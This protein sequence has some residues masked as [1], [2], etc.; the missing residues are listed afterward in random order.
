MLVIEQWQ[1]KSFPNLNLTLAWSRSTHSGRLSPP[2]VTSTRSFSNPISKYLERI[3]VPAGH[4]LWRQG[5][6]SA[7]LYIIE[8]GV[9][10]ASYEFA[11]VVQVFDESMVA[12]TVAGEMSAL[13]RRLSTSA[14]ENSGSK[15]P[16]VSWIMSSPYTID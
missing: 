12:G 1:R 6:P 13:S 8:S 5:D 15:D 3:S 11:N 7:G 14:G 2:M 4:V 9:L 16:P 10:R